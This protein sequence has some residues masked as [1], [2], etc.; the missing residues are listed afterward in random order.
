[1]KLEHS[2]W[3]S[4]PTEWQK[5]VIEK[6]TLV[7]TDVIGEATGRK[8]IIFFVDNAFDHCEYTVLD[9]ILTLDDWMFLRKVANKIA[10]LVSQQ[11]E[12]G[13]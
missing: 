1:M 10:E 11:Q 12:G 13:K 4:P 8:A 2:K 7:E 9:T 3:S 5:Q 6:F